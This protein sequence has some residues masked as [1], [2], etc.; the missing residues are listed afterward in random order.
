MRLEEK[1]TQFITCCTNI[2]PPCIFPSEQ[3]VHDMYFSDEINIGRHI[4]TSIFIVT[5]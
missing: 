2:C 3:L 4:I 1:C 5:S